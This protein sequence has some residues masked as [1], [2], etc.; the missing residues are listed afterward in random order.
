[1]KKAAK[2]FYSIGSHLSWEVSQLIKIIKLFL[3]LF[4]H[5]KK[6]LFFV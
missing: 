6:I 2:N 3:L 1:L 4:V 5:K